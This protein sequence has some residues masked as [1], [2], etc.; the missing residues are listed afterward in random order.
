MSRSIGELFD[1]AFSLARGI[2][3]KHRFSSCGNR[4]RVE[5]G[6]RVI[7]Q[8]GNIEIGNRSF[9]HRY[10]KLSVC[11]TQ[12][13]PA[14]LTLGNSV[15]V[16]D[17]T[18]IHAG[19]SVSIGDHTLIAWDCCIMDR[20]YHKMGGEVE[21]LRPVVIGSHVW[22]G[23]HVLIMKGV[24]IGDGAVIAAGSVVTKDVPAGALVGGNPAKVIKEQVVWNP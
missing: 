16:G 9:L 6:V 8:N 15:Y 11:G 20:D 14:K 7:R 2:W 3:K 23:C 12:E 18:E 13:G 22:I 24:T 17:R 10:V 21:Q 1:T 19:K 5:K 4:L